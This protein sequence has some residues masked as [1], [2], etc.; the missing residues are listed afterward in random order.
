MSDASYCRSEYVNNLDIWRSVR[1]ACEGE[2]AVKKLPCVL[3]YLNSFDTSE[4]NKT[5]N[6][7][8]LQR[9]V[10]Y[11]ATGRTRDGLIGLAFAKDPDVM[12]GQFSYLA[13]N[14][15][16][17]GISIYHAAQTALSGVLETGRHGFLTDFKNDKPAI[18]GYAAEDIIN[19]RITTSNG[20]SKLILVVLK[21]CVEDDDDSDDWEFNYVDQYRVYRLIDDKVTVTLYRERGG[22]DVKTRK[23]LLQTTSPD[24]LLPSATNKFLKEIPFAPIGAKSNSMT[25]LDTAPL[26][27]LSD[28]NYAHFRD[29]ADY[30][31][32]VFFCGQAQAWISGLDLEWRD[33]LIELGL[34]VGSRTPILLP[35]DGSFGFAQAKPNQLAKEAMDNKE[36]LMISLGARVVEQNGITKT[37]TQAAGD[38]ATGTSVLGLA[39]GNV[40]E[41]ITRALQWCGLF[42]EAKP[43][44]GAKFAITQKFDEMVLDPQKLQ[45]VVEA[46]QAGAYP[47][48]DLRVYLKRIGIIAPERTDAEM[49]AE[50]AV[51]EREKLDNLAETQNITNPPEPSPNNKPNSGS[52]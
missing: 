2:R 5:R 3:P 46:W 21:E 40:S 11:A 45:A 6:A 26:L 49:D 48:Q 33:K 16:G 18:L 13:D 25:V 44:M 9:A 8:Y 4:G 37:A 1:A 30:Q 17:T 29:S 50:L 20:Q 14:A 19:W 28:M 34:Y 23:E 7:Q 38:I 41:A 52:A 35:K 12:F 31:D 47:K 51:E 10:W 43:F 36:K 39:S 27:G 32:S 15:D 42:T 22:K 24:I